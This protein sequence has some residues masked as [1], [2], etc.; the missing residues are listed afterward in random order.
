[1]PP[2]EAERGVPGSGRKYRRVT[3]EAP[4]GGPTTTGTVQGSLHSRG[5]QPA[6]GGAQGSPSQ[7]MGLP[8]TGFYTI[9]GQTA[10]HT[11]PSLTP[12][13]QIQRQILL[14]SPL[15]IS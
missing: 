1:M 15:G 3:E 5:W 10:S 9:T 8:F 13:Y 4:L 11:P 14:I 12:Q 2:C 7:G 6:A